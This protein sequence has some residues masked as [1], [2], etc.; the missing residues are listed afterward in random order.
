MAKECKEIRVKK[1]TTPDD[2]TICAA[3]DYLDADGEVIATRDHHFGAH[4]TRED[5]LEALERKGIDPI[6]A[7]LGKDGLTQLEG[8]AISI[9]LDS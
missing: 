5:I 1:I 8:Q 2:G 3:V 7:E 4:H 6:R 9:A